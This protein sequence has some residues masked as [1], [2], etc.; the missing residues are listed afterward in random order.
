MVLIVVIADNIVCNI[1]KWRDH[2]ITQRL[3]W[4]NKIPSRKMAIFSVFVF[5]TFIEYLYATKWIINISHHICYSPEWFMRVWG[6]MSNLATNLRY[7]ATLTHRIFCS[8]DPLHLTINF[9]LLVF[10]I[11]SMH[12]DCTIPI[13]VAVMAPFA[14]S[15]FGLK[16]TNIRKL[17]LFST[18]IYLPFFFRPSKHFLNRNK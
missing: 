12:W 9:T 16:I 6:W 18:F 1:R 5:T 14:K 2:V 10:E 17:M 13:I 3:I 11:L 8:I 4:T 7:I 15:V